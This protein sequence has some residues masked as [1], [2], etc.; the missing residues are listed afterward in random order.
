[1]MSQ[2][3]S[4]MTSQMKSTINSNTN[5]LQRRRQ[6]IHNLPQKSKSP[7]IRSASVGMSSLLTI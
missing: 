1:M 6:R 7:R 5:S 2:M 4:Q 3:M